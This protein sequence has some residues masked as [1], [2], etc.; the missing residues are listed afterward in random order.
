MKTCKKYKS[1]VVECVMLDSAISLIL[2]STPP[3]GPD[4]YGQLTDVFKLSP[5]VTA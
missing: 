1:P 3:E 4:E 2:Q 5:V